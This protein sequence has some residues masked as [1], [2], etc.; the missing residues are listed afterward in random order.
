MKG[1]TDSTYPT[2]SL[3][4]RKHRTYVKA[5]LVRKELLS[6]GDLMKLY[7]PPIPKS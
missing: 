2:S 1:T 6:R 7:E 4:E 3:G 5:E